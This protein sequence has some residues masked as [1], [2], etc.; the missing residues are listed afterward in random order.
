MN[1][2]YY[3]RFEIMLTGKNVAHMR[4]MWK[5]FF[6]AIYDIVRLCHQ[7][8]FT[9]MCRT[10]KLRREEK[11]SYSVVGMI[12]IQYICN[13][14][15]SGDLLLILKKT[16]SEG[17]L[18]CE[19]L[20]NTN[21]FWSISKSARA[22]LNLVFVIQMSEYPQINIDKTIIQLHVLAHIWRNGYN[23]TIQPIEANIW[24]L[25]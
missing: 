14:M 8:S 11:K 4:K 25:K 13:I 9:S 7:L 15:K 3:L 12:M 21:I 17:I 23:E 19:N 16:L 5:L 18:Y 1:I 6:I 10:I 24:S 2:Y 22:H 20:S